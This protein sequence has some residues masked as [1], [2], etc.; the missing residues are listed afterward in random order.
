MDGATARKN[1]IGF[2]ATCSEPATQARWPTRPQNSPWQICVLFYENRARSAV[3]AFS[4]TSCRVCERCRRA[5]SSRLTGRHRNK[6][7]A[8]P[9]QRYRIRQSYRPR[10]AKKE[11]IGRACGGPHA[12]GLTSSRCN[13]CSASDADHAAHPDSRAS[14]RHS[15]VLS[16]SYGWMPWVTA[17]WALG[18]KPVC[19]VQCLT[20]E[21]SSCRVYV[22]PMERCSQRRPHGLSVSY[23]VIVPVASGGGGALPRS[24]KRA[25][26]AQRKARRSCSSMAV[27]AKR[28]S[29]RRS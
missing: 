15:E 19:S 25:P 16:K 6:M 8:G 12:N 11:D 5:R 24:S 9:P 2:L 20:R 3:P 17:T 10:E 7:R 21:A 27:S 26:R 18:K 4:C 14:C 13:C 1:Y 28:S 29:G 23:P 22:C